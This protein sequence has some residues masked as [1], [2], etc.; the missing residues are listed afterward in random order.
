MNWDK[1]LLRKGFQLNEY[2]D[3]KFWELKIEDDESRKTEICKV[4][5]ADIELFDY[6]G[7]SDI[8]CLVL[9]SDEEFQ[10]C[11]FYY[12]CNA[13][14]MATEDFMES[15]TELSDYCICHNGD[16]P[17]YYIDE[18]NNAFIDSNGVMSVMVQGRI[19][20]FQTNY[21]PKCGKHFE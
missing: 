1:L 19:M 8:E 2:P 9:Q 21:C 13:W 11:I 5:G 3:G 10:R 4:F 18:N 16:E 7:I 12:D 20:E 6:S 14:G 15:V 17:I